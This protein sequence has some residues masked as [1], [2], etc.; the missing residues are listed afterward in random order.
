M[1][2]VGTRLATAFDDPALGGVYKLTSVCHPGGSWQYRVKVSE[3]AAKTTT[4]GILQVRRFLRDGGFEAD[5]HQLPDFCTH[6]GKHRPGAA[7]GS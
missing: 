7:A 5:A 2:C 3:Q 1:W 4:P 6:E